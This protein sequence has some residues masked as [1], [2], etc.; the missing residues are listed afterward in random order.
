MD[1]AALVVDALRLTL[2]L[3]APA[4]GACLVT[5]IVMS[6]VQT[7]S[8]ANDASVGFVPKLLAVGVTLFLTRDLLARE[9]TGFSLRV[10]SEMARLGH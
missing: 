3:V 10:I 2:W 1:F 4:L 8:Q 5:S 9:L 6:I 7:A